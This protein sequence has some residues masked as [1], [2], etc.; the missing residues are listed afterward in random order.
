MTNAS[1]S[2]SPDYLRIIEL[3][4]GSL[5][6]VILPGVSQRERGKGLTFH[7]NADEAPARFWE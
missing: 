6:R 5:L 1:R 2:G 3:I 4:N 7:F